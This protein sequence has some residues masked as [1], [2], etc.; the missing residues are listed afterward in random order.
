MALMERIR[1]RAIQLNKCI[2]LPEGTEE[3]TIKAAD[4][5]LKEGLARIILLGPVAEIK[6]LS[7]E[8]KIKTFL[9]SGSLFLSF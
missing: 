9:F 3:R 7:L 5:I 6:K 4:F 2:V 1:E 8:G